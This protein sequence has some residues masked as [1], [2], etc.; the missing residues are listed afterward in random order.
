M[1]KYVVAKADLDAPNQIPIDEPCFIIRAQDKHAP[2]IVSAYYLHVFREYLEKH[3]WSREL[4][5]Q[6]NAFLADIAEHLAKIHRWQ[7]ENP[8]KVKAPD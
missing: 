7:A 4:E 3:A 2:A 8:D 1:T 5:I 6:E